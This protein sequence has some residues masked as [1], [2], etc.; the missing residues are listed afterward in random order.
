MRVPFLRCPFTRADIDAVSAVMRTAEASKGRAVEDLET[1][2]RR[3]HGVPHA[4]TCNSGTSALDLIWRA[5][6]INGD[7]HRGDKVIVPSF[8]FAAVA[9]SVAN[10][11]LVPVFADIYPGTWTIDPASV[12]MTVCKPKAIVAVHTFGVP[13]DM[14]AICDFARQHHLLLIEDCAESLGATFKSK[15]VGSFGDAAILSFNATKNITS[16]EGG[17]VLTA[18]WK[19]ADTVGLLREHGIVPVAD[20]PGYRSTAYAGY[21]LR[22]PNLNAAIALSQFARLDEMN[23]ARRWVAGFYRDNI[24]PDLYIDQARPAGAVPVYQIYATRVAS[25]RAGLRDKLFAALKGAG[26]EAKIYFAP[27]L[28]LHPCYLDP[29]HR[30]RALPVTERLAERIIALPCYPT[31]PDADRHIVAS[32]LNT[33]FVGEGEDP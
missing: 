10:A 30:T 11:G 1:A 4:I 21:G 2:L 28:H 25:A 23:H 22:L 9:A 24:N 14:D 17:A 8:T 33:Y 26:I 12:D 13:C 5:Y 32:A 15:K 31:V 3:Y 19:L 6:L 18:S 16:G 7:L 27:P 29:V 20:K